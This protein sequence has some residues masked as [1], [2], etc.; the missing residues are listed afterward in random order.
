MFPTKSKKT[1]GRYSGASKR[2]SVRAIL[3][4]SRR[5]PYVRPTPEIKSYDYSVSTS[6]TTIP[7]V[8]VGSV[9]GDQTFA[10]GMAAF[11]IVSNGSAFY[12]RN[13]SKINI[14]SVQLK[15]Q[16]MKQGTADVM[17]RL[18]LV[19]DRQA[20]GAYPAIGDILQINDAMGVEFYS[21]LNMQ[22]KSRFSMIRDKTYNVSM[23]GPIITDVNEFCKGKPTWDSEF[24]TNTGTVSDIRTGAMYLIAFVS[25]LYTDN[26]PSISDINVRI[27]YYDL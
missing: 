23:G 15:A 10:T 9:S 26:Y 11:N 20:N 19:Y 1:F 16:I 27:R 8:T 7:L 6:G 12:Q 3:T 21:G 22:N 25:N 4:D 17:I 13:G 14:K 18:M 5:R 24:S 2:R